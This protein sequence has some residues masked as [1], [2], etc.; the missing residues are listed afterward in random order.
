MIKAIINT[1]IYDFNQFIDNGYVIFDD[2]IIEVGLMIEFKDKGYEIIDG[3]DHLVMPGLV[4]GHT[5]I[6]ST[7]ARGM[8]VP[9]HPKNFQDILDQLWWKLDRNLDNQTTYYS[10]IVSAIDHM[11][12]GVTTLIDHHASGIEILGSLESLKK[13]VVDQAHLRGVFAFETSDR[14]PVEK[15]IKE[16]IDFS[17]NNHSAFTKGLFGLHAS[18]SLSEE[19]LKRVKKVIGDMPIHIHV[20]ESVLDEQDCRKKYSESILKRL[21]RHGLLN[22]KSIIAH[23]I[24]VDDEELEIIKNHDCVI[25][26]NF[27]SNMNNSVGVP[28]LKKFRDYGIPVIVG[29]DGIS[30]AITTEYLTLYYATHLLDQTPNLFGLNELKQMINDTYDYVNQILDIK[31][32]KIEKGYVSDLLMIPYVAPT[33]MNKDN[34]F[35]HVFFGLFHSFKPK[36]VYVSG[37]QVVMNYDVD[38]I[39]KKQYKEAL[40]YAEKLWKR[41]DEE[42]K[43]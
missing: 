23:A 20:A 36:D 34:A 29:N 41:I 8:S 1:K 21:E 14:F 39:L 38:N 22:P 19:T 26:V 31:S 42:V 32:G 4:T 13:A 37:C 5:H 30:S 27:S 33:P 28:P 17:K 18:M 43:L 9:F 35:G 25:A 40:T 15:A 7:F 6:Y 24:Y 2:K 16:N 10:G 11:K 3:Y 12:N